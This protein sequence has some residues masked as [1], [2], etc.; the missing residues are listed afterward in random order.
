MSRLSPPPKMLRW[1]R[2]PAVLTAIFACLIDAPAAFAAGT[3]MPW[4]TPINEILN[5]ITGPV[6]KAIGIMAIVLFGLAFA[7]SEHG[8][9]LRRG[10]GIAMGVSI[11]FA[12]SSFGMTFFGFSGGA[13][14]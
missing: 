13:G 14:F 6:A 3:G 8:S 4:E 7:F 11:A 2:I 10:L 12:A 9:A 1:S 5:S